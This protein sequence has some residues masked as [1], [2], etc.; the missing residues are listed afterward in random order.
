TVKTC[1]R[2]FDLVNIHCNYAQNGFYLEGSAEIPLQDIRLINVE[3]DKAD[4]PISGDANT[5]TL[6]FENVRINGEAMTR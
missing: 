2:D 4:V 6:S 3:V 5:G 1:Y